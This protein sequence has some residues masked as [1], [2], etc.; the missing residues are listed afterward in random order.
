MVRGAGDSLENAFSK[1]L[2]HL[3]IEF[4]GGGLNPKR[5]DLGWM[6]AGQPVGGMV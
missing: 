2:A 3:F 5:L 4:M 1:L 6:L